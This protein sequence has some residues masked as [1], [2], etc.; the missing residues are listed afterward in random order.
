MYFR[1]QGKVYIGTRDSLGNP[2]ALRWVGNCPELK[3]GLNTDFIEHKESYTGQA[4]TDLKIV[5]GKTSS[6]NFTLEDFNKDN[7]ALGM[8]G[9]ALSVVAGSAITGEKLGGTPDITVLAVGQ[10]FVA[11]KRQGTA[12]VVKDSTGTPKTLVKDVNY[13]IDPVSMTITVLDVTTGGPYLGPLK[14]DYTPGASTEIAMF[15]QPQ[16]DLFLRFV[17][18]NGAD[19]GKIVSVDLYKVNLAPMKELALITDDLGQLQLEGA[20]LIDLLKPSSGT[21]GQFGAVYQQ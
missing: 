13:S 3:I 17:G 14:V 21:L 1:G 12:I 4:V 10:V 16:A 9:T 8:Q 2:Q 11:A 5:K 18:M 6:L 19:N 20:A 15:N 7:L